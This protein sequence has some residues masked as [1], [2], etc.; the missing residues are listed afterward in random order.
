M[1]DRKGRTNRQRF[2]YRKDKQGRHLCR[3]CGSVLTGRKTSFCGPRCLRDFFMKTDWE[4]V[5]NVIWI[6]DGGMCMKCGKKMLKTKD[7]WHVDHIVPITKGGA[8]WDLD[9]L[10]LS[11]AKCNL[12]KG[13]KT[14]D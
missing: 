9:N 8:E 3:V 14:D 12:K 1:T 2:P 4:R 10:E 11:C 13:A 7:K 5:R 6:R